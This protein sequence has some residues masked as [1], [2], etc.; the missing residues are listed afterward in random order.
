MWAV[1][2]YDQIH[3]PWASSGVGWGHI[4]TAL[5]FLPSPP[6]TFLIMLKRFPL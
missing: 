5:R 1:R 4:H 6:C 2:P 3:S